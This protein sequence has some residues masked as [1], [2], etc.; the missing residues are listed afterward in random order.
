M[1][2]RACSVELESRLEACQR[3]GGGGVVRVAA[4]SSCDDDDDDDMNDPCRLQQLPCD[5]VTD[6]DCCR[7]KNNHHGHQR[8]DD[9]LFDDDIVSRQHNADKHSANA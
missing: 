2:T 9:R 4:S 5:S 8:A 6:V 1:L 3:D 7:T